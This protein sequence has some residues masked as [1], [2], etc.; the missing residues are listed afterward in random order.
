MLITLI[1]DFVCLFFSRPALRA[2]VKRKSSGSK[3][4]TLFRRDC[5]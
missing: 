5:Y 4:V 1:N 3:S 2:R